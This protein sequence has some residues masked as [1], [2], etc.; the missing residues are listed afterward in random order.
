LSGPL[1]AFGQLVDAVAAARLAQEFAAAGAV[2]PDDVPDEFLDPITME[3][4]TE[5][6]VLPDSQIVVDR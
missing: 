3:L 1:R 5:P 6:V 2:Q 4:M